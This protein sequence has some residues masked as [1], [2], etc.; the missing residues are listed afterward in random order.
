MTSEQTR[1]LTNLL[2]RFN[3]G[4]GGA[5][6][7]LVDAVYDDLRRIAGRRLSD[8]FDQPLAALTVQATSIAHD[9]VMELR[10]QRVALENSDQFFAIATRLIERLISDYRK[11]RG[12]QKRGGGSRGA[13]LDDRAGAVPDPRE[14]LPDFDDD[15]QV[16]VLRA[17]QALHADYP[18]KAEVVTLHVIC[19]HSLAKVAQVLALSPAQVQRD[20]QFARSWLRRALAED[21]G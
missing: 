10:R 6:A 5:F 19:G 9:A 11:H 18:R 21:A 20:W 8:R 1:G 3:G 4:E 13:P 12:A 7:Q 14:P 15:A 16:P 17:L 2:D